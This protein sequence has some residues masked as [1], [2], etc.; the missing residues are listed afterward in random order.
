[1]LPKLEPLDWSDVDG[2]E[3]SLV[4]VAEDAAVVS[5]VTVLELRAVVVPAVSL[6]L[7][8]EAADEAP[9][10]KAVV[11]QAVPLVKQTSVVLVPTSVLP[12]LVVESVTSDGL[13]SL[14]DVVVG[15]T[16]LVV[17][18]VNVVEL[19]SKVVVVAAVVPDVIPVVVVPFNPKGSLARSAKLGS[20]FNSTPTS[21]DQLLHLLSLYPGQIGL[22]PFGHGRLP[23]HN[24]QMC[25][26]A[27]V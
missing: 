1:M 23:V 18:T 10:V 15:T 3:L 24:H 22:V 25:A 4:V 21:L 11:S 12:V 6:R 7:V 20:G 2:D 19:V 14:I 17:G 8:L 9:E 13:A 16:I 27:S 5:E 26:G